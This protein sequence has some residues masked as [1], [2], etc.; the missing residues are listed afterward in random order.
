MWLTSLK[1][2]E[3]VEEKQDLEADPTTGREKDYQIFNI[4]QSA[5][6]H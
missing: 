2:K 4:Y 5:L 3:R 1:A 6:K